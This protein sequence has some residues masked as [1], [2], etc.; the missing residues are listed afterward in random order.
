VRKNKEIWLDESLPLDLLKIKNQHGNHDFFVQYF[1]VFLPGWDKGFG[2]LEP[3]GWKVGGREE[4]IVGK[5]EVC[6]RK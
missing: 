4:R 2:Y 6:C 1:P 5:A 3:E